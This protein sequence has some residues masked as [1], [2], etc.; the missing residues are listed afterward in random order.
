MHDVRQTIGQGVRHHGDG[1]ECGATTKYFS[2]S[3]ALGIWRCNAILKMDS[4]VNRSPTGCARVPGLL[5]HAEFRL[6]R[7][8]VAP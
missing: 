8:L 5:L 1:R 6:A 3:L 7:V 2:N 4:H